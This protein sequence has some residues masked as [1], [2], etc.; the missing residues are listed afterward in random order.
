MKNKE[1]VSKSIGNKEVKIKVSSHNNKNPAKKTD[2]IKLPEKPKHI[3]NSKGSYTKK[4]RELIRR[5][6]T[7]ELICSSNF[8]YFKTKK[9]I[10]YRYNRGGNDFKFMGLLSKVKKDIAENLK[11]P[12]LL[13][14]MPNYT[15]RNIRYYSFSNEILDLSEKLDENNPVIYIPEAHEYDCT[16]AYIESAYVLGYLSEDIYRELVE[17]D[18]SLRLRILG[19]I[20]TKKDRFLFKDGVEVNSSSVKNDLMRQVWFHIC[21]YL[22]NC[23]WQFKKALGDDFL[24]YW[25][26]GILFKKSGLKIAEKFSLFAHVQYRLSFH[27]VKIENS[28]VELV[29]DDKNKGRFF[30]M[31]KEDKEKRFMLP[32]G[33]Q[34]SDRRINDLNSFNKFIKNLD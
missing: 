4:L 5:K 34:R 18:K 17:G 33:K 28:R 2:N 22:D 19:A 10:D 6:E 12:V 13:K 14:K 11:N 9:G 8:A 25:V 1:F 30:V 24:F 3:I 21:K 32:K 31:K 26:D 23:M 20:A 16:K 7:F 29:N 15:H 27:D